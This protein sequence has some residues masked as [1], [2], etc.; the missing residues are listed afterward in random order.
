MIELNFLI[1]GFDRAIPRYD[2]Y[3]MVGDE[4]RGVHNLRILNVTLADINEYQCQVG[5]TKTNKPIRSDAHLNVLGKSPTNSYLR[6][7]P[8]F[9]NLSLILN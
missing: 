4:G 1:P 6:L 9:I 2:R 3:S 5:P 8:Q 7:R